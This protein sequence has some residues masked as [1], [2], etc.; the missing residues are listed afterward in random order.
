MGELLEGARSVG[1]LSEAAAIESVSKP[2]EGIFGQQ[3]DEVPNAV[4]EDQVYISL[5]KE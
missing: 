3:L 1:A 5:E 2:R 4:L